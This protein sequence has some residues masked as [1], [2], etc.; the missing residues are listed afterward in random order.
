MPAGL[1]KTHK[2]SEILPI[3]AAGIALAFS[4]YKFVDVRPGRCESHANETYLP[5][6]ELNLFCGYFYRVAGVDVVRYHQR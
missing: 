4:W 5:L 3:C 1:R 2:I 6:E